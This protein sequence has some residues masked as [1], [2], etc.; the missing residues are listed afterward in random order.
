LRVLAGFGRWPCQNCQN[1]PGVGV[2]NRF[3]I[4]QDAEGSGGV[5]GEG[6]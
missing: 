6:E 4:G 1:Y 3:V 5:L 2:K